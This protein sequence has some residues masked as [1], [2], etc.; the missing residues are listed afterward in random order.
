MHPHHETHNSMFIMYYSRIS[1]QPEEQLLPYDGRFIVGLLLGGMVT[2]N[3]EA[4]KW[5]D[6]SPE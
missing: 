2:H 3:L 1:C 4:L 6:K 5:K